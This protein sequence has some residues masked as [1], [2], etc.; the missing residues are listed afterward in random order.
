M[1]L[2]RINQG[3][4][5]VF[6]GW[7]AISGAALVLIVNTGVFFYSY[8][9]FLPAMCAEF[10]WS[11]AEVA[12]G[13]SIALLAYGLP[14][15]IIGASVARFGP[16]INMV[17]GNLLAAVAMAGMFLIQEVWHLY[18]L[19]GLVGLGSGFGQYIASTTVANNWFMKKRSLAMGIVSASSGVSGFI[20][21]P[22]ITVL[23][24]SFGWR[25][26]W[27]VLAVILII[28][29][30]LIGGLVLVRNRPEDMG[31]APDGTYVES[32]E[33]DALEGSLSGTDRRLM[34]WP[35]KRALREP[36]TW[37]IT[38]FVMANLFAWGTMFAHQV[39]YVEESGFS[40]MIAAMTLSTVS[41]MSVI[42]RMGFGALALRYN[43]RRLAAAGFI[44][45]FV[46]LGIIITTKELTLI[47][48]YAGLFGLGSGAL[49]TALPTIIGV[50]FG[51][52]NYA[53]IMGV[54][55]ALG[56]AAEAA[57]STVTGIIYDAVATYTPAFALLA[58]FSLVGL[59]CASLARQPGLPRL[60]AE[61]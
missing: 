11:R 27:L 50:Y 45:Q 39:A 58:V 7:I 30:S 12:A 18:L 53:M 29:A 2:K 23:I 32:Y 10:G 43:V 35:V 56:I 22:I 8:G 49:L 55:W 61:Q 51:R 26:S 15:P 20:F 33:V 46:S 60:Q 28:G 5:R 36:T 31:Q 37:F 57:G 44:I 16:R 6:Y 47:Y 48:V 54:I 42:G 59:I 14:S 9:V 21:P 13:L 40:P 34:E 19:Y 17:L 52:A 25:M 41:G 4:D 38:A 1:K 3:T 24:S